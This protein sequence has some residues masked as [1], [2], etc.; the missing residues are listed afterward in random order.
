[1]RSAGGWSALR[2]MRNDESRMKVDSHFKFNELPRGKL[3]GIKALR[4]RNFHHAF[5]VICVICEI[6]G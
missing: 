2:A 3:R 6:C 5:I 4:F 1:V